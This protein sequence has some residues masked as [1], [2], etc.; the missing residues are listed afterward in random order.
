MSGLRRA[1]SLL[2][3]VR[4]CRGASAHRT[5]A[6]PRQ[7]GGG[8]A[9]VLTRVAGGRTGVREQGRER[10]VGPPHLGNDRQT[11]AL[12]FLARTVAPACALP[13]L[14]G[15]KLALALVHRDNEPG[16]TRVLSGKRENQTKDWGVS[17][18]GVAIPAPTSSAE[19]ALVC[20][21]GPVTDGSPP[22]S[23]VLMSLRLLMALTNLVVFLYDDFFTS[24]EVLHQPRGVVR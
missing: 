14:E 8:H 3:A 9:W 5:A 11:A 21:G 24:T 4:P 13:R 22:R 7:S 20:F 1:A 12:G 16:P 19:M 10:G 6:T 23:C 2:V 15:D 17:C 18:L